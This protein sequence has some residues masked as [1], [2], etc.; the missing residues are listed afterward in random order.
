MK[1]NLQN[2]PL[3]DRFEHLVALISSPRFLKKEGLGNEVPFFICPFKV[4]ETIEIQKIQ[5]R[6]VKHLEQKGVAVLSLNLYD[7]CIDILK[8]NGDWEWLV[9]NEHAISKNE[10]LEDMQSMLDVETIIIPEIAERMK[11]IH[12]DVLF[13]TGVGE[14]FPYIR[15]HN[16]LNNLQST[17]T[18]QPAVLFFPG[19][20]KQSPE[21]GASLELFGKLRDD[22]YYRA[23]NIFHCEI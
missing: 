3:S 6:L 18:E 21:R 14:V 17:V 20:Y 5:C 19:E 16:V 4:S 12:F 7:I 10:L 23:F 2:A 9:E 22:K 8:K 1:E 13:L 15:S 11:K